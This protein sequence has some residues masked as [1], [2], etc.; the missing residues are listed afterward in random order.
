MNQDNRQRITLIAAGIVVL[1]ILVAFSMWGMAR[2]K[3]SPPPSLITANP[4]LS[5]SPSPSITPEVVIPGTPINTPTPTP[6]S[7]GKKFTA[8]LV[9]DRLIFGQINMLKWSPASGFPGGIA[10]LKASDRSVVGWVN[11]A[12]GPNQISYEWNTQSVFLTRGS[13]TKKD[14]LPGDYILKISFDG[15]TSGVESG[16]FSVVYSNEIQNATYTVNIINRIF[17]PTSL[18][19]KKNNKIVFVN[20]D[21]VTH[22]IL[23]ATFSPQVLT[24]GQSFEFDTSALASGYTYS[25]ESEGYPSMKLVVKVQ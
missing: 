3:N 24:P 14:I 5:P 18:S 15:N 11:S 2:S 9:G 20:N 17:A 16:R 12:I 10:L 1:V 6:Q 4:P 23:L 21:S 22:K 7:T 25:F 13:P 19:V 8:P